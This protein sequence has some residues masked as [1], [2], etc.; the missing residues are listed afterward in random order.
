M[1][2]FEDRISGGRPLEWLAVCVVG[3][4]EVIDALYELLD[5]G[6]GSAANGLVGDQSKESLD[7][8][9][10]RAVGRDEVHV[11]SNPPNLPLT[12]CM[13]MKDEA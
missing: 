5:A 1:E 8:V 4:D 10:P 2:L 3:G 13:H 6:E 7:L 11:P 9:Q 12:A